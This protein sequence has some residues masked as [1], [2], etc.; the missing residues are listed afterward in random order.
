CKG[1]DGYIMAI[2]IGSPAEI[3]GQ[4]FT[5]VFAHSAN[6]LHWELLDPHLHVYTR[7]RYSACPV[8]RYDQGF[9]YMIY[10]EGLPCHRWLPYIVRSADLQHWELGLINPIMCFGDEDKHV[11]A[12][13]KFAPE[14]L[15]LIHDAVNCNNSD[16]DLCEW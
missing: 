7:E 16:I 3:A 6:L 14:Q 11:I 2:E 15:A 1:N 4:R 13:E 9:Y 8:I 12:P 10:L 5:T